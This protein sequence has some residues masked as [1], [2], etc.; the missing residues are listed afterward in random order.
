[1]TP[2]S[3]TVT[4][5]GT[6]ANADDD[7]ARLKVDLNESN[8]YTA[9]FDGVLIHIHDSATC[10]VVRSSDNK[11]ILVSIGEITIKTLPVVPS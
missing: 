5:S 8:K 1:M 7:S 3:V 9:S 6:A 2:V 11:I 10:Y 4:R